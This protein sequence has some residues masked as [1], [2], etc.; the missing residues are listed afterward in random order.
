M[1]DFESED[2]FQGDLFSR[3]RVREL[4]KED[5]ALNAAIGLVL[6]SKGCSLILFYDKSGLSKQLQVLWNDLADRFGGVNFFGVNVQDRTE[7][8]RRIVE[9]RNQPNH[10]LNKYVS[11][12]EPYILVYRENEPGLSYPQAFYNGELSTSQLSNWIL[13][14]ACDPGYT[15]TPYEHEGTITENDRIAF[16]PRAVGNDRPTS[17]SEYYGFP[18]RA[19]VERVIRAREQ[20]IL[21][22]EVDE[23]IELIGDDRR[24][25]TSSIRPPV[26][27]KH[28]ESKGTIDFVRL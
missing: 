7:I 1:A 25:P 24:P 27:F 4:D 9:I 6:Y 19:V 17:S 28:P 3:N 21:N 10:P 5:F 12:G 26:Q 20:E 22:L 14:L 8:M 2:T 15:E 18:R 23:D 13:Q 11:R 16:D